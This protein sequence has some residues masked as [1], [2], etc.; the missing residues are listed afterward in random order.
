MQFNNVMPTPK[1]AKLPYKVFSPYHTHAHLS[2]T[3]SC[4]LWLIEQEGHVVVS[5]IIRVELL[6][7]TQWRVVGHK[8]GQ[9]PYL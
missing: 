9:A 2:P 7:L 1:L 6:K 3:F 4:S 5:D 8:Q